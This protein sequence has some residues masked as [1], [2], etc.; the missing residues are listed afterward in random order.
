[1]NLPL[2]SRVFR[3]CLIGIVSDAY[4][5]LFVD[6]SVSA[7]SRVTSSNSI[8]LKIEIAVNLIG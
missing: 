6:Y 3:L 4:V 5:F 2:R 1:M 8:D 7:V